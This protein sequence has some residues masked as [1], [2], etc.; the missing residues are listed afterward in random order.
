MSCLVIVTFDLEDASSSD[1]RHV[2]ND[3]EAIGL[4]NNAI[5]SYDR[6]AIPLPYNTF[7]REFAAEDPAWVRDVFADQVRDVFRHC[8]VSG[9]IFIGVGADWAWVRYEV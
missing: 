1:Y 2:R 5:Q 6:R 9:P 4:T 8:K 3:L 7:A